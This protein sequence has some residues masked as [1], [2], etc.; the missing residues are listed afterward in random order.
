MKRMPSSQSC[1]DSWRSCLQST[2]TSTEKVVDVLMLQ[3][4]RGVNEHRFQ[5]RADHLH[6]AKQG[7]EK[8]ST[9][10]KITLMGQK[11]L[12]AVDMQLIGLPCIIPAYS[13]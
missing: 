4:H 7:D 2:K 5:I 12:Y 13:F 8:S 6:H 9:L 11:Y 1:Y 3:L 10:S